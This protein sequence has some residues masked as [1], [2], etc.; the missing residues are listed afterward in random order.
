M[1][2]IAASAVS[3]RP[4]G[5]H[6]ARRVARPRPVATRVRF[7]KGKPSK[8]SPRFSREEYVDELRLL[9]GDDDADVTFTTDTLRSA[10]PVSATIVRDASGRAEMVYDVE[11]PAIDMGLVF[12]EGPSHTVAVVDAVVP[13][14]AAAETRCVEPGDVLVRCTATVFATGESDG[15][16]PARDDGDEAGGGEASR[17]PS[18]SAE[19]NVSRRRAFRT[20]PALVTAGGEEDWIGTR[21]ETVSFECLGAPFDTQ[22]AAVR[23]TG[24]VDAGF[25]KRK[26]RLEFM[27]PLDEDGDAKFGRLDP[28]GHPAGPRDY[29]PRA[30]PPAE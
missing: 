14:S 18:S 4:V 15:L 23:S 21:H 28:A 2:S 12:R 1:S 24:I 25:A 19:G 13:E 6:T 3:M 26:V 7:N 30:Y 11:L 29:D 9:E 10:T 16:S 5:R 20:K 8:S 17:E 27:R 22:M